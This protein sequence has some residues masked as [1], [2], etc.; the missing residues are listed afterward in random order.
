MLVNVS[1]TL[2]FAV[3]CS[4]ISAWRG[5]PGGQCAEGVCSNGGRPDSPLFLAVGSLS[6][7]LRLEA[8]DTPRAS[9]GRE[10]DTSAAEESMSASAERPS[11]SSSSRPSLDIET[12]SSARSCVGNTVGGVMPVRIAGTSQ[13]HIL[14]QSTL[15]KN[16]CCLTASTPPL[17]PSLS[18]GSSTS[19]FCTKSFASSGKSGGKS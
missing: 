15:S 9:V 11:S 13:V 14:G 1:D 5:S 17:T 6:R 19:S 18:K 2:C 10:S 12:S 16:G 3:F 7:P 4:D 8:D